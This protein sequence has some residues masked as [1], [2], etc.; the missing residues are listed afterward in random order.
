MSASAGTAHTLGLGVRGCAS[1]SSSVQVWPVRSVWAQLR[2]AV[3]EPGPCWGL[4][5]GDQGDRHRAESSRRGGQRPEDHSTPGDPLSANSAQV[6]PHP[7]ACPLQFP[8]HAVPSFFPAVDR[9]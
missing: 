5:G 6:Q 8:L 2:L 7:V 9:E 4:P 3:G 1:V